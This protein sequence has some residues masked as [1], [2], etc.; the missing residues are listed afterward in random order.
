MAGESSNISWAWPFSGNVL[1]D[2]HPWT[3]WFRT[4]LGQFGFININEMQSDDPDLE[5]RIVTGVGS[6]G[7]Q[8]G[9]VIEALQAVCEY[10][11]A[12]GWTPD[13]RESVKS[14]LRLADEIDAFKSAHQ[15][16][17]KGT[18]DQ[19]VTALRRLKE[20]DRAAYERVAERLRV[21]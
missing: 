21:E 11:E 9:R 6:Y 16:V 17:V 7:K 2:Y 8:L 13:G 10:L 12:G 20:Q 1:Q 3:S 15:P 18:I 19:L 14:F 5:Q 4:T